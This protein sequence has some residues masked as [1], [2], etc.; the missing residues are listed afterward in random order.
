MRGRIPIDA[1]GERN[2]CAKPSGSCFFLY[3]GFVF[4]FIAAYVL[5]ATQFDLPIGPPIVAVASVA[6]ACVA[7]TQLTRRRS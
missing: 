6:L 3:C 7:V 2:T 5:A 1:V 4:L